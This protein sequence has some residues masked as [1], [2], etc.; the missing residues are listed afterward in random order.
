MIFTI[1]RLCIKTAGRD[2]GQKCV[3]LNV[4]DDNFVLIDGAT[5][6][7]KVNVKHLEPLNDMVE[8]TENASHEEVIKLFEKNGWKFWNTKPKQVPARVRKVKKANAKEAKPAVKK[9]EKKAP[10]KTSEKKVK[11]E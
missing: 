4:I 5:R 11:K 3:I 6:R 10:V 1:G 7:K 2:A 8:I 9:E